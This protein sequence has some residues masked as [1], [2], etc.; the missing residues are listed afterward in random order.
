MGIPVSEERK[1][2]IN[3]E[4]AQKEIRTLDWP[5]LLQFMAQLKKER[6]E[7]SRGDVPEE[8]EYRKQST[9][10]WTPLLL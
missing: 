6:E 5:T 2:K 4:I 3:Q 8:N 10:Q 9:N 1:D 7:N